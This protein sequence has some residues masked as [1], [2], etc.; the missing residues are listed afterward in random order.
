MVQ[1]LHTIAIPHGCGVDGN[2]RFMLSNGYSDEEV[3]RDLIKYELLPEDYAQK[4]VDF[5]KEP[6]QEAYV[7]TYFY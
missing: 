6:F 1:G 5:L 3:K 4:G 2:A 7:F